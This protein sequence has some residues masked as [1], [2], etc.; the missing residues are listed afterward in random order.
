MNKK[1]ILT[2]PNL[3]SVF[4]LILIPVYVYI[5]LHAEKISD[6]CI[7]AGVFVLSALTDM[8]DGIIARKF[9]M[10][11]R[12]GKVLDPIADKATQGVLMVCLGLKY[13]NMLMLF[14]LFVIKEGFMAIMGIVNL[15]HEKM[16]D[17]AKMSGKVCTT[18]LF[19]CMTIIMLFPNIPPSTVNFLIIISAFF[20][21][22]SLIS[23]F[24][25]Y[26]KKNNELVSIEREK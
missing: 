18:V 25:T 2:I 15:K 13:K 22:V 11:S 14:F 5:Y 23:Y 26:L 12:V 24:V 21:V 10:I 7:A 17:G 3:L 19:V 20:M 9:N 4:R 16:L 6:Y 1:E 8:A